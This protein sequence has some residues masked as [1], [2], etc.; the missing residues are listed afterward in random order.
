MKRRSAMTLVE[1]MVAMS[2]FAI[3]ATL[4]YS[5]FMQTSR[6]K[7]R[8]ERQLDREHE[9]RN[10]IERIAQE[11]ATAYC[12]VQRNINESL[13]TMLTGMIAKEE[14]SN[15]K[16]NFTSFSHRRLYRNAH[17]SDQNE[18]SYFVTQDP[19]N[20]SKDVLARREQR[21]V[22]EDLEKGGQTQVLISD[23]VGFELS[24]FDPLTGEWSSTWDTTQSALQPNRLPLQ[25][26][27]KVTVP[28]LSGKGPNQTFGTRTWFPNTY[29]LNFTMYRP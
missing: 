8:V 10:G 15:S 29:A 18:L 3:V 11:L 7:E 16:V 24:F 19:E 23:V 17:E 2:I 21:R 9:I 5:G 27:I 6:N 26:K 20:G 22:D 12:S 13:R 1:V 28:N 4:L 14:G 25:A